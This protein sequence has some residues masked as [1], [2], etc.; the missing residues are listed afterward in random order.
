MTWLATQVEELR[1]QLSG[2]ERQVEIFAVDYRE[3]GAALSRL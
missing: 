3:I 2:L 1:Q